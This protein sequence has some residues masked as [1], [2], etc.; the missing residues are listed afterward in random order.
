MLRVQSGKGKRE[1]GLE[2][3]AKAKGGK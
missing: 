3:L 2:L 1:K